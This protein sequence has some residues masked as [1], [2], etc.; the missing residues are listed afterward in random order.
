MGTALLVDWRSEAAVVGKDAAASIVQS[1]TRSAPDGSASVMCS[2][3]WYVRDM[4]HGTVCTLSEADGLRHRASSRLMVG[5]EDAGLT[6]LATPPEAAEGPEAVDAAGGA[7]PPP[8][9]DET[10]SVVAAVGDGS[11]DRHQSPPVHHH[12]EAAGWYAHTLDAAARGDEARGMVADMLAQPPPPTAP[13]S[14]T[15]VYSVPPTT[16]TPPPPLPP[17]LPPPPATAMPR[18]QVRLK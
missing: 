16:V 18:L 9:G 5:E 17:L 7:P 14:A 2:M 4:A 8:W 12:Q 15:P 6:H 11:D 13:Q 1:T 3:I 10:K